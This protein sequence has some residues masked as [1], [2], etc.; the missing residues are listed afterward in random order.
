MPGVLW[1]LQA[2]CGWFDM[3]RSLDHKAREIDGRSKR[4]MDVGESHRVKSTQ[5]TRSP[6]SISRLAVAGVFLA[7]PLLM[8]GC[9]E[10]RNEIVNAFETAARGVV[11]AA[12]DLA[13]DQF[14]TDDVR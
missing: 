11:D 9:P 8:G 2:W 13:F 5:D 12:L 7:L 6:G 1:P 14:R 3:R 10:F 4:Q